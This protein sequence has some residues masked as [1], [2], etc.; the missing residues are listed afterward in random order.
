M[1]KDESTLS[2]IMKRISNCIII[3]NYIKNYQLNTRNFRL[4]VKGYHVQVN[5]NNSRL[6]RLT[7]CTQFYCTVNKSDNSKSIENDKSAGDMAGKV[8]KLKRMHQSGQGED[9]KKIELTSWKLLNSLTEEQIAQADGQCVA[10]LLANWSYF[11]KYWENGKDGPKQTD[12][13]G[14]PLN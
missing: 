1:L 12:E 13:H 7:S 4:N 3:S 8:T 9:R 5:L 11:A 6:S 10:L 2:F 14:F